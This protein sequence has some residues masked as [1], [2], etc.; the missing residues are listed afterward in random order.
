MDEVKRQ[1][2][3]ISNDLNC[4]IIDKS[5]KRRNLKRVEKKKPAFPPVFIL[6][7]GQDLNWYT[8]TLNYYIGLLV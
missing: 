5:I 3:K 6:V 2:I 1:P 4:I 8:L 7:P